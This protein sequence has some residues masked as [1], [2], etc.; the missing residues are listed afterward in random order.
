MVLTKRIAFFA[1]VILA[2]ACNS[3]NGADAYGQF[4]ADEITISAEVSGKLLRFGVKEG[5]QLQ[6]GQIVGVID[7]TA[8]VLKRNELEASIRSIQSKIATLDAQKEVYNAQLTTAHKHLARVEKL[9]EDQAATEQQLDDLVGQINTLNAQI[10]AVDI[11]KRSVYAEINTMKTRIAQINDQI[12]RAT[13]V[14][15]VNGVV[16]TT[17]AEEEELAMT[18]KPLYQIANLDELE[19]RV[20]VSGAQLSNVKLNSEVEVLIDAD[21]HTNQTLRG[22]VTWIASQAEFTPK[23][24][25]T[26]EERVTQV[27][28]VKVRVPNPDGALKIGMPGEVNFN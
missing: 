9:L 2:M 1:A 14:N 3:D 6:A 17:Y 8:M 22:T 23:M 13:I 15:P 24:I 4:E 21:E 18:G 19:L 27:Y 16:L 20:F 26:K 28:A 10:K 12:Q 7:T 11:Q 25:Q 5:E